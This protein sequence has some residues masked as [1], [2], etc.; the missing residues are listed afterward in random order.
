MLWRGRHDPG[1]ISLWITYAREAYF[2][3]IS[4]IRYS[5]RRK[6]KCSMIIDNF[7]SNTRSARKATQSPD[8]SSENRNCNSSVLP[9][10][11]PLPDLPTVSQ[12]LPFALKLRGARPDHW[13][14]DHVRKPRPD[15]YSLPTGPYFLYGTLRNPSILS[16]VLHLTEEP[17]MRPACI[18]GYARKMWGQ[19]PALIDGE[20]EAIVHGSVYVVE[21]REHAEWLAE[22][23]TKNYAARPCSLHY[24][25][26]EDGA[27]PTP[28]NGVGG[29]TFK[30]AGRSHDL[31][32]GEFD[33]DVWLKRMRR[34]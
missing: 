21:K 3:R 18:V 30:Y 28:E 34:S 25:D 24:T 5:T 7:V 12:T 31:S 4:V 11:P 8:I 15:L 32:E 27:R 22:Y 20:P 6:I 16:E 17:E 13:L 29:Y 2:A 14:E 23:E 33:L 10:P 26:D 9:T 1:A 19:Y